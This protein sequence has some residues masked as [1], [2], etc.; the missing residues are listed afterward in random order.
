MESGKEVLGVTEQDKVFEK[1]GAVENLEVKEGE[2]PAPEKAANLSAD[3]KGLTEGEVKISEEVILQLAGQ[4]LHSLEGVRPA[5]GSALASFG[6]GRKTSGGVRV[7]VDDG[8]P[9]TIMVDTY[10]SVKYGLRIPDVAWEV[11]EAV[12]MHLEKFTGY[13]VKYVNVFIQGIHLHEV[14]EKVEEPTEEKVEKVEPLHH[15]DVQ[16]QPPVETVEEKTE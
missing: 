4:A 2:T 3:G 13:R 9:P 14:P 15:E 6:L 8:T 16:P 5:G 7:N 1:K 12:K 10:I 11:Q